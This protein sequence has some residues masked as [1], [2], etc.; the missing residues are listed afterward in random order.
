[1]FDLYEHS[2]ALNASD[3][4]FRSVAATTLGNLHQTR[5]VAAALQ[6]CALRQI[7]VV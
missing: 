3:I 2:T 7:W 1:V 5:N 6:R 4:M